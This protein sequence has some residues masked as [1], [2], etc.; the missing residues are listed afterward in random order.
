MLPKSFN[1]SF[2][3]ISDSEDTVTSMLSRFSDYILIEKFEKS[4][5]EIIFQVDSKFPVLNFCVEFE[6]LQ[7]LKNEEEDLSDIEWDE[8]LDSD[9]LYLSTL[10]YVIKKE[11]IS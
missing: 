8:S 10:D 5:L 1:W 2:G 3:Q 9:A 11:I 4:R 6:S 7:E